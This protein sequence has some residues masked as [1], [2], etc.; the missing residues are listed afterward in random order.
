MTDTA[1]ETT[2][3]GTNGDPLLQ[4]D[5]LVTHFPIRAGLFRRQVGVVHCH[6]AAPLVAAWN[7]SI[8]GTFLGCV[9]NAQVW[10]PCSQPHS[11]V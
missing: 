1:T 8:Y 7:P 9:S 6:V 4:V 11:G 3:A 5:Q 10:S 2:G